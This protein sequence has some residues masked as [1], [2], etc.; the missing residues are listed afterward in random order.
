MNL[1]HGKTQ[2]TICESSVDRGRCDLS[3]LVDQNRRSI[4][5]KSTDYAFGN[6]GKRLQVHVEDSIICLAE[7]SM[8]NRCMINRRVA[9]RKI[10]LVIDGQVL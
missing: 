6:G 4:T 8:I 1:I 2:R 5:N 7:K 10:I 3:H 9:V